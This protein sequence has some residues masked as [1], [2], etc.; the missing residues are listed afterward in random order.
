MENIAEFDLYN[1]LYVEICLNFCYWN[2]MHGLISIEVA[3]E[4]KNMISILFSKQNSKYRN[5]FLNV[6]RFSKYLKI[7]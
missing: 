2:A 7:F 5:F 6:M 1:S 4:K 3:S